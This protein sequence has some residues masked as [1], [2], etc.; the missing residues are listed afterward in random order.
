MDL[1]S[2]STR[3][4]GHFLLLLDSVIEMNTKKATS[5]DIVQICFRLLCQKGWQALS[6]KSIT[7]K[8]HFSS[9]PI[10]YHFKSLKNLQAKTADYLVKK[11]QKAVTAL[12]INQADW[13]LFCFLK[14]KP[15]LVYSFTTEPLFC[16]FLLEHAPVIIKS[17]R[18]CPRHNLLMMFTAARMLADKPVV[19][20]K[21]LIEKLDKRCLVQTY[22]A[23]I[24]KA[25]E[26]N[27]KEDLA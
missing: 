4:S 20:A 19:Q 3:Q 1:I 24:S 7:N 5:A 18:F 21:L 15:G 23:R 11:M 17:T 8:G 14:G 9:Y 12:D 6:V 22:S 27:D 10:Y 2:C 13:Q 16:S 25:Q 26:A